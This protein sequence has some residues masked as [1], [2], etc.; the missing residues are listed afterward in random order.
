MGT[1]FIGAAAGVFIGAL[2]LEILHRAQP[3]FKQQIESKAKEIVSGFA[4]AFGNEYHHKQEIPLQSFEKPCE[5]RRE[6]LEAPPSAD[7]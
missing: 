5:H 7:V 2:T 3:R 4:E 6:S 1:M